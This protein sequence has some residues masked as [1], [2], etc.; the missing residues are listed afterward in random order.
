M[1]LTAIVHVLAKI[2]KPWTA[3]DGTQ[4]MA[5]SANIMQDNGEIIST[6]RLSQ[7]QYNSIEA[8]KSYS[9]TA[10]FNVGKNGGYLRLLDFGP[11][12]ALN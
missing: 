9:V 7:E 8:N 12:K 3:E 6:I 5:C 1:K 4:K 11:A 10:L 2:Q